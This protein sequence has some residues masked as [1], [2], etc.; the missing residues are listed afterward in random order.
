[1]IQVDGAKKIQG[2]CRQDPRRL[3]MVECAVKC[4][5][6]VHVDGAK[7]RANST[8]AQVAGTVMDPVFKYV[9]MN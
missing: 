2:L 4:Q 7:K 8:N 3:G 5:R 1:V 9:P 6:V